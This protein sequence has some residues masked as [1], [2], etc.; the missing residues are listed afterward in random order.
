M[1]VTLST[2][3]CGST[4]LAELDSLTA[5]SR[6]G[7]VFVHRNVGNL[8]PGNDLNALSVLEYA[9]DHLHVKDI[10]VT[11]HYDC[12]AIK[13]ATSRQDLGKLKRRKG[14]GS[15]GGGAALKLC[16]APMVTV[17]L[18]VIVCYCL[19]I[20]ENWLRLV[21]DVYRLHR[22]YLDSINDDQ[23][24]LNKLVELN[25][26]E[27]CINLYKTGNL[28]RVL[29]LYRMYLLSKSISDGHGMRISLPPYC[30]TVHCP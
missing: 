16:D 26:I 22:D 12:G 2:C 14:K 19:G 1:L 3:L 13:A 11:G 18:F 15:E 4:R 6:P 27:Q 5:P 23:E 21:R 30:L 8:V 7:E 28:E 17:Y 20:L 9:V 29:P 24:R 10:I 25:V